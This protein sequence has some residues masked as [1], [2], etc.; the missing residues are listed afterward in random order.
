MVKTMVKTER[1]VLHKEGHSGVRKSERQ[2]LSS[3]SSY[4][5][6]RRDG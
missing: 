5:S 4:V 2:G 3:H 6:T 1:G